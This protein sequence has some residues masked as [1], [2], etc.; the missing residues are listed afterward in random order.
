MPIVRSMIPADAIIVGV[1]FLFGFVIFCWTVCLFFVFILFSVYF[2]GGIL[3]V[4]MW[5]LG[6]DLECV[7]CFL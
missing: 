7:A 6:L 1:F 2:F 4:F 3:R 5:F